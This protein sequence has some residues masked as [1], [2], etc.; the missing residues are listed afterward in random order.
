MRSLLALTLLS[1]LL[2]APS[3]LASGGGHGEKKPEAEE[4]E[5]GAPRAPQIDMP[6]LVA[7]VVVN[8]EMHH[9]VYLSVTLL[10]TDD[11]HKS[12][13]LDKI[14]YLQDAFL[15]EA[16]GASIAYNNDPTIVDE[17]GLI[18]RLLSVCEKVAG[19]NIVKDVTFKNAA[20]ATN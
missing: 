12:M 5:V 8:G 16:H 14:P 4:R 6:I 17:R 11:S 3:A 7:P 1:F 9:Y 20:Q 10:L 15:R 13:M 2:A 19:P 18:G